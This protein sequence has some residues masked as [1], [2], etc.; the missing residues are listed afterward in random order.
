MSPWN[1]E[2]PNYPL[3]SLRKNHMEDKMTRLTGC[4]CC[5]QGSVGKE[6]TGGQRWRSWRCSTST[7][8]QIQKGQVG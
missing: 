5:E 7:C 1:K 3:R 4:Q 6:R 8:E 2:Q